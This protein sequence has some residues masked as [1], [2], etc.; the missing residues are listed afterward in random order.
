MALSI[1]HQDRKMINKV[2]YG[3]FEKKTNEEI[4]YH[5]CFC[6]CA[7]QTTFVS[8]MKVNKVLRERDFY[9]KEIGREELR[10][11]VKSVRFLRKADYLL[12]I[13]ENFGDI[14]SVVNSKKDSKE[15]RKILVNLVLGFGMKA[16]SHFL[17]NCGVLD[18]AIIDTHVLKFLKCDAP[19]NNRE[20][21]KM[22][23]KF[24][25]EADKR[26]LPVAGLDVYIWIKYS[27]TD[28]KD[29]KY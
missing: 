22:E 4:F 7:P 20:Y 1:S 13:K 27:N 17:R 25:E 14:I 12:K 15:K 9:N 19:K 21:L 16:A 10:G 11:I 23:E 29:H 5:V 8:N 28:W 3:F 26:N 2:L 6:V 24:K 18:L